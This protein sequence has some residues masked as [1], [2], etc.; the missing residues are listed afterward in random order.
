[1]H[2]FYVKEHSMSMNMERKE[3][4][5]TVIVVT[6]VLLVKICSLVA[7]CAIHKDHALFE[8]GLPVTNVKTK[9]QSR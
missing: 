4:I 7:I 8:N 1:M 9:I 2:E 5:F 3:N 6:M